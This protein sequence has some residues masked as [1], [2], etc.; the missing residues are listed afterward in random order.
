MTF[1]EKLKEARKREERSQK[2]CASLLGV[3]ISTYQ[4]YENGISEPTIHQIDE[5]CH[6]LKASATYL[7]DISEGEWFEFRFFPNKTLSELRSMSPDEI[8]K[9]VNTEPAVNYTLGE[10][11][12]LFKGNK[13]Y[14]SIRLLL[15]YFYSLNET[16]KGVA[17]ERLQELTLINKYTE[18]HK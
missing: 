18:E 14:S 9:I 4:R 12:D 7:C 5:I 15:T 3:A 6:S 10:L 8:T 13:N 1:G 17:L 11:G 16:G 2:W